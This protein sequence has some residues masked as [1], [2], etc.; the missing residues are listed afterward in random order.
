M[1]AGNNVFKIGFLCLIGIAHLPESLQ[2]LKLFKSFELRPCITTNLASLIEEELQDVPAKVRPI[3]GNLFHSIKLICAK[4]LPIMTISGNVRIPDDN[5]L[6]Q[7]EQHSDEISHKI[8]TVDHYLD[9]QTL[10]W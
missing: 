4:V 1:N 10:R 5:I 9:A 6:Q 2:K 3:L 8:P 7:Y